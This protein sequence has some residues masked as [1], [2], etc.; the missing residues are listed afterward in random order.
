MRTK[1][2]KTRTLALA[3]KIE[4]SSDT[5]EEQRKPADTEEHVSEDDAAFVGKKP[6][7]KNFISSKSPRDG[8]RISHV[9]IR[10]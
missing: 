10:S 2:T 9:K 8:T 3:I 4:G 7:H 6:I 5:P 1:L